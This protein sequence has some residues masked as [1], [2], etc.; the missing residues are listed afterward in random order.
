[1]ATPRTASDAIISRRRSNRSLATPPNSSRATWGT[2]MASPT[3]A[4][5]AGVFDS[6]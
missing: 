3:T 5:A 2:V 1:M 6:S 4:M